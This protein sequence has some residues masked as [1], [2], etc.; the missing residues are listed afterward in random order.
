MHDTCVLDVADRGGLTLED[1]GA[2]LDITRERVRQI[3]V[4]A[5]PKLGF[6]PDDLP[7]ETRYDGAVGA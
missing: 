5:L 3:E 7:G 2:R 6:D 1:T 4:A